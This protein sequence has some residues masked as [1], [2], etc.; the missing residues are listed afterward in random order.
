[1]SIE[2]H[3]AFIDSLEG[4]KVLPE[5]F[6]RLLIPGVDVWQAGDEMQ[7]LCHDDA[8]YE[9]VREWKPVR[10]VLLG[11]TVLYVGRRLESRQIPD[12][13]ERVKELVRDAMD[14]ADYGFESG[15]FED[16]HAFRALCEPTKPEVK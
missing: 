12:L 9:I 8:V 13:K 1:M 5:T 7:V 11:K 6:H 3:R 4:E 14:A 10:D 15:N 16:A 2:K